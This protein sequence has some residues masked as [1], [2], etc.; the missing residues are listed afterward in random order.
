MMNMK[1]KNSILTIPYTQ[2]NIKIQ[3]QSTQPFKFSFSNGFN[4]D[5]NYHYSSIN[6]VNIDA[7]KENNYYIN[8]I[9]FYDIYRYVSL[10]TNEFFSFS[11]SIEKNEN[12][13]VY[14]N[15]EQSSKIDELIDENLEES[16]CVDIIKNL[17]NL[18][19]IYVFSDIAKNP[20]EIEGIPNYHHEKIDFQ[21]R[22]SSVSTKNRKFYEFYQELQLIFGTVRDG[23]LNIV[24]KET[25]LLTP[26]S[27]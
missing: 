1:S 15:Y 8:T 14:L 25:P 12:Q 2:K 18:F 13:I 27:Q 7:K 3:L 4:I 9:T 19:E 17:K 24:A 22:L 20:P 11:I 21:K 16:Y 23:H 5:K 6:N 26:L 10:M